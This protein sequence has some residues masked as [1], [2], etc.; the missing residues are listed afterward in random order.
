MIEIDPDII[1]FTDEEVCLAIERETREIMDFWQHNSLGWAPADVSEIFANSVLERQ[2]SLAETL[3]IWLQVNSEGELILAW[4]NLGAQVEGLMKLFLCVYLHDYQKAEREW[5]K[6]KDTPDSHMLII[7]KN[8]LW[9]KS[10]LLNRKLTG[11]SG[12][13]P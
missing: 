8:S 3:S 12:S 11:I 1:S 2:S 10:G 6:G 7:F 4:A 9:R 13:S 5:T